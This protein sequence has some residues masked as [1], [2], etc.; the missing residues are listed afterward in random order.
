MGKEGSRISRRLKKTGELLLGGAKQQVTGYKSRF[1]SLSGIYDEFLSGYIN[2]YS[3]GRADPS[4]VDRFFGKR[5]LSFAGIDGTICKYDVF[6]LIIFFAGAYSSHGIARIDD[7]G[8]IEL[9]YEQQFLE[10]GIGLSSV[11][12]IYINEVPLVDQTILSR[13]EDGS[14]DLTVTHTDSW[15][16]DNSAFADYMMTL[17]EFYLAYRLVSGENPVDI[18]LMDRICSSEV[19]SSYAE[20]SDFRIDI[21]KE[22]GLVGQDVDGRPFSATEWVQAR[23]LF[24]NMELCTPPARGEYLLPRIMAE[25]SAERSGLTRDELSTRMGI[26]SEPRRERLDKEL[27]LAIRGKGASKG[28][29]VRKGKHFSLRPEYHDLRRRLETLVVETCERLFSEDSSISYD[30]RFKV[31]KRWLTTNDLSFLA[32]A[33]LYLTIEKSWQNKTLLIGVAK[34]TSARDLK[35]QVIPVLNHLGITDKGFIG[36]Q[37]DTPDTDR[38]ILQWVSLQERDRLKTPWATI[39]YDAAFK[40]IVPHFD[41]KPGLVSG[42]RRNQISLE[43]TFVK[44]YFQLCEAKS[45]PRLRSNVLLY[46]RLVYPGFDD[47]EST[48]LNLKHDYESMLEPIEAVFYYGVENPIQSFT[49]ALFKAMTSASIPELFGHLKPLFI[50]DKV[51]KYNFS[52]FKNMVESAGSW[53][54]NRPELREFLFYLSTFRERRSDVEQSRRRA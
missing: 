30:E 36:E 38:M 31:N 21:E 44:A 3:E 16:I 10:R 24:G 29:V 14:V 12:P 32:L 28:I 35:R 47:L 43:K 6:D 5:E 8:N 1:D 17:S 15:I 34:D 33:S 20:T 4:F 52:Q 50:A 40:T 22:C 9:E 53:L 54:I 13:A 2:Q 25:L 37:G 46:D 51:A 18:L 41:R 42:A 45:N 7:S 19:S 27:E 11:L 48:L 39:E 26:D 23:R 49:I